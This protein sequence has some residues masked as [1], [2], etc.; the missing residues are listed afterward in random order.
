MAYT[1]KEREELAAAG[2][3]LGLF[4]DDSN[5]SKLQEA[6]RRRISKKEGGWRDARKGES[7]AECLERRLENC[8]LKHLS[9]AANL[10]PYDV[11]D[12]T[13]YPAVELTAKTSKLM[14]AKVLKAHAFVMKP[15][16]V[17]A[18][19]FKSWRVHFMLMEAEDLGA[20]VRVSARTIR[21]WESGA[22]PIPFSMW[23]VMHATLQDPEYFL[24][25]PGF[26][27]FYIEWWEGKAY[28]CSRTWPDIRWTATDLY[29]NRSA[30]NEVFCLREDIK[31]KDVQISD[32]TAENT[33]LRQILKTE[34]IT[35][36]LQAMYEHI[37]GLMKRMQ[38]AD[39]MTFDDAAKTIEAATPLKKVA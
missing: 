17:T 15:Q 20:F 30:L 21:N 1:K 19:E 32:L 25:R 36:E 16:G 11:T 38:T 35:G 31:R 37:G 23:W 13:R 26:H 5:V 22:T 7:D 33:R 14:L 3:R 4:R 6:K 18:A 8:E 12:A 27:D 34:G 24:T 9:G 39:V 2:Q 28:F 29:F 10:Q